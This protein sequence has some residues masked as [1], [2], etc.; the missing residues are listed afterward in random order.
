MQG[1]FTVH[2]GTF[3]SHHARNRVLKHQPA[4]ALLALRLPNTYLAVRLFL[5]HSARANGSSE[6]ARSSEEHVRERLAASDARVVPAHDV[7]VAAGA[8]VKVRKDVLEVRRLARKVAPRGA[9]AEGDGDVVVREVRDEAG[10]AW[11][12]LDV[13]P[14][15]V[16]GCGALGEVVVDCEGDGGE[17]GEEVGCGGAFGW[18]EDRPVGGWGRFVLDER[19]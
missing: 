15:G 11:E 17:E 3:P 5:I 18:S 12:E 2:P 1:E 16:L 9:G 13:G 6:P 14:A 10:G 7:P 4:R 8:A 19:G